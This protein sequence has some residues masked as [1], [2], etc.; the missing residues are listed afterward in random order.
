MNSEV[1]CLTYIGWK[2]CLP[3]GSLNLEQLQIRAQDPLHSEHPPPNHS[4]F[5]HTLQAIT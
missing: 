1:G 2:I 3:R 4:I 5:V